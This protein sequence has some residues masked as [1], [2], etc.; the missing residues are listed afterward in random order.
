MLRFSLEDPEK[1]NGHT[2]CRFEY[3]RSMKIF[4]NNNKNIIRLLGDPCT[5]QVP[6]PS[7]PSASDVFLLM[8]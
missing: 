6:N 1:F 8:P 2:T 3:N 5:N 4:N 7:R